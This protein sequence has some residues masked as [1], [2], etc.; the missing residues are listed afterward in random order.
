[1][2]NEFKPTENVMKLA[3]FMEWYA[4]QLKIKPPEEIK[5]QCRPAADGSIWASG[6]SYMPSFDTNIEYRPAPRTMTI[7][8]V[9]LVAPRL[10]TGK[11]DNT[12]F[13]VTFRVENR[14]QE[15]L[16]R[17][18]REVYSNYFVFDTREDCQAY[19]DIMNKIVLGEL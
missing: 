18:E 4:G 3:E 16:Q 5:W 19:I 1:M 7:N 9:E 8:G 17:V 14:A 2:N 10:S 12:V 6:L 15:V 11:G 13:Q